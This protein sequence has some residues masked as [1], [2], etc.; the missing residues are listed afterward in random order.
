MSRADKSIQRQLK[1]AHKRR[2][3]RRS[4][5]REIGPVEPDS[6]AVVRQ[7]LSGPELLRQQAGTRRPPRRLWRWTAGVLLL[8]ALGLPLVTWLRYDMQNVT[9]ANAA[10]RGNLAEIGARLD[11]R[12]TAVEVDAGERVQAG[13]ILVRFEDEHLRA[14]VEEARAA[15][16]GLE[17]ALEVERLTIVHEG[18]SVVQQRQHARANVDAARAQAEAAGIY[19]DNARETYELRRAL[20][21]RNGA[22]SGEDVRGAALELRTAEAE[23]EEARA[24]YAAARSEEDEVRLSGDAL[25]IREHRIGVLEADL[26]KSRARLLHAEANLAG[27]AIRAP[28]DG[29]IVRRLAQ[30]GG[31]VNLGQP[32]ISML[33]GDDVWIEAWIDEADIGAVRIG[34]KVTVTLQSFPSREFSGT[35]TQIGLATDYELPPD[36]VPQPRDSRMRGSPVVG[37]RVE[38][39]QPPD[40][41]RPGLSA[42][43]AIRKPER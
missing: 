6:G 11:G 41:L 8:L 17:R 10:V 12:V 27:A 2:I 5:S 3:A 34:S 22:I 33:L 7:L 13:D 19:V 29:S 4:E 20:H 36:A 26:L 28:A 14:E 38:L 40:G 43:V 21:E 37:V 23:L 42:V 31:S 16:G 9:S 32:V 1:A 25:E 39:D 15:I 35:V 30:P 24:E 18:R